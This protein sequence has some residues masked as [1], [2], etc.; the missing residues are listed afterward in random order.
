MALPAR[1]QR[2]IE[3]TLAKLP[4][5]DRRIAERYLQRVLAKFYNEPDEKLTVIINLCLEA[6]EVDDY[7]VVVENLEKGDVSIFLRR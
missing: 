3:A 7:Y 4:E 5:H 1:I 6:L 2:R